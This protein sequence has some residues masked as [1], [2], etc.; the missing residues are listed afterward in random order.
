MQGHS[1]CPGSQVRRPACCTACRCTSPSPAP[2]PPPDVAGHVAAQLALAQVVRH[3]ACAEGGHAADCGGGMGG[4]HPVGTLLAARRAPRQA[5]LAAG[6]TA[7]VP[8]PPRCRAHSRGRSRWPPSGPSSSAACTAAHAAPSAPATQGRAAC[9]AGGD[10]RRQPPGGGGDS[11]QLV[12]VAGAHLG[13]LG[14]RERPHG[15]SVVLAVAARGLDASAG[16]RAG[17]GGG[18]WW[19]V[20]AGRRGRGNGGWGLVDDTHPRCP[21]PRLV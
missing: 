17:E 20:V 3:A 12:E 2:H 1:R 13:I 7:S 8:S 19:A 6:P 16:L 4:E 5:P 14:L 10:V 15:G 18:E 9:W 11:S 21:R